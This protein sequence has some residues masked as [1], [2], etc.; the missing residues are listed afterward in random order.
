MITKRT[1][2]LGLALFIV[3]GITLMTGCGFT[4]VINA[5]NRLDRD[6]AKEFKV[7]KT[8]VAPIT[9]IDIQ[10]SIAEVELIEA[11]QFYVE[12]DYLYWDEKPE[13]SFENG[14]LHFDDSDCY[15]NSYSIN[16]NLDNYIRIYLP[17]NSNLK[18]ISIEDSSGDVNITGFIADKLDVTVSYGDFTMKEAAAADADITLSSGTSRISDFQVS[19]LE[20]TNSYGNATFTDINTTSLRLPEGTI[21]EFVDVT[22]SSGDVEIKDL[23]SNSIDITNSYGDITMDTLTADN[24]ELNLSSGDCEIIKGD[25]VMMDISNSYGDVTLGLLGASSDYSLDLD[26]SY[27]KIRVGE[28]H[29]EDH[30]NTRGKGAGKIK[31]ELSSGDITIAFTK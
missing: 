22:M 10:T 25:A 7:E 23:N 13:Y 24:L 1:K 8:E 31:A 21:W 17:K 30:V 4:Y 6:D 20:Y 2:M 5:T 12:I 14:E 18:N 11:E 3:I 28:N 16:F 29:Y 27:G 15:P 19:E 9:N 26:T